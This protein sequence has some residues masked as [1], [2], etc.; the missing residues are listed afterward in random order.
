VT[1]RRRAP[2]LDEFEALRDTLMS[3]CRELLRLRKA[4]QMVDDAQACGWIRAIEPMGVEALLALNA[5]LMNRP[6]K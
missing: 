6:Q 4:A 2:D 3:K 5:A 1:G